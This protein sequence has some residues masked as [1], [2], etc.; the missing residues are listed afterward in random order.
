[1]VARPDCSPTAGVSNAFSV[2]SVAARRL[3][4]VAVPATLTAGQRYALTV[5]VRDGS[6]TRVA[7][8]T[9]AVTLALTVGTGTAGA[10]LR[11]AANL[12]VMDVPMQSSRA[13]AGL[14]QRNMRLQCTIQDGHV[15]L[16]D[17]T[18]VAQVETVMLKAPRISRG[19]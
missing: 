10:R 16:T 19:S 11:S 12:T 3:F 15:L 4:I 13:M 7:D 1:M 2:L 17:G 14:A 8:A 18:D 6:G 9:D 5:E